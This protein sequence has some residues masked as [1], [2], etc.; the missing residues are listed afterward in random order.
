MHAVFCCQR[1]LVT[2]DQKGSFDTF[3]F[4]DP[5]PDPS[6]KKSSNWLFVFTVPMVRFLSLALIT[7]C[8]AYVPF[9]STVS[10]AF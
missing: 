10:V 8:S 4:I 3:F 6:I 1:S 5:E 9:Q 2:P 7:T